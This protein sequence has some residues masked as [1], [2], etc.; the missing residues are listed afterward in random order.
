MARV[1]GRERNAEL[2]WSEPFLPLWIMPSE[3]DQIKERI[4]RWISTL[5]EAHE[6]F[7]ILDEIAERMTKPLRAMWYDRTSALLKEG[8][9][10]EAVG[11]GE[12]SLSF[13][14]AR[15]V[16]AGSLPFSP[17]LCVSASRARDPHSSRR[18]YHYIP[19]A[20]DDEESWSRGL[21]PALFWQ[22]HSMH[23]G[24]D[25]VGDGICRQIHRIICLHFTSRLD[26]HGGGTSSALAERAQ[27]DA[28]YHQ[29]KLA[30]KF[31]QG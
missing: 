20:G 29:L 15:H 28:A 1:Q 25:H 14:Q 27:S 19:G 9:D 18:G 6:K 7:G 13:E 17:I 5:M 3:R 24:D 12:D 26:F 30:M 21:T 4:G 31:C 23:G 16:A 8:R 22:H 11:H 2:N 10:G